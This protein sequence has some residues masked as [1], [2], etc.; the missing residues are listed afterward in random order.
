MSRRDDEQIFKEE[1]WML[2][3]CSKCLKSSVGGQPF[4]IPAAVVKPHLASE[5]RFLTSLCWKSWRLQLATDAGG[6]EEPATQQLAF[7]SAPIG[8]L[9]MK[10]ILL[11][12][13]YVYPSQLG[14]K[15]LGPSSAAGLDALSWPNFSN[16]DTVSEEASGWGTSTTQHVAADVISW[17]T[18]LC[19][20]GQ[21]S[22]ANR[23]KPYETEQSV[24]PTV[25]G[26]YKPPPAPHALTQPLINTVVRFVLPVS[27]IHWPRYFIV[28]RIFAADF[29]QEVLFEKPS[30]PL[31]NGKKPF[32]FRS[33]N[34]AK[35]FMRNAASL[36]EEGF[37]KRFFALLLMMVPGSSSQLPYIDE[38]RNHPALNFNSAI[39]K[40]FHA[41][42]PGFDTFKQGATACEIF[43]DA[44]RIKLT[45]SLGNVTGLLS[46]ETAL[47]LE[48]QWTDNSYWHDIPLKTSI[49]IMVA[50]LSS[51]V[52][53]GEKIRRNPD[54]LRITISYTVDSFIA[55]T[56]LRQWLALTRRLVANF[57]P[58]CC[59]L[60]QEIEQARAI[61]NPALEER[62]MAKLAAFSLTHSGR[63]EIVQ[64]L[65]NEIVTVIQSQEGYIVLSGK[66]IVPKGSMVIVA[67][68]KMWDSN[69]YPKRARP[70]FD[71][72]RFLKLRKTPGH[73]TSAQLV[74]PSPEHLVFG[75][76]K[77]CLP[78]TPLCSQ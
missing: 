11:D 15:Q 45:Q 58:S 1:D 3:L 24:N 70:P 76:G 43:Q 66:T 5:V 10:P 62:R 35:R 74:S 52:F 71:S 17:P 29:I 50:Q 55:A 59:K 37:S 14:W 64:E 42:F 21:G 63:E 32:E 33:A 30:S 18:F 26:E 19:I 7:A 4:A 60:R 72:Y 73:E 9:L 56:A 44:V 54:W 31:I 22:H 41:D 68:N 78:G 67:C 28:S 34:A 13:R 61:I 20:D 12:R 46:S 51:K 36:I 47:V 27:F 6:E 57:L 38:I 48:T 25:N 16:K 65:R 49:L 8:A 75:F 69:I 53:L 39:S 2:A 40:E 23:R 77:T